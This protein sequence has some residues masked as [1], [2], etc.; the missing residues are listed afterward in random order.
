MSC[1]SCDLV[2]CLDSRNLRYC[3]T[4]VNHVVLLSYTCVWNLVF[5]CCLVVLLM[6]GGKLI[7]LVWNLVICFP[8]VIATK[9]ITCLKI[10]GF[11]SPAG[12]IAGLAASQQP[13]LFVFYLLESTMLRL[14]SLFVFWI[15]KTCLR[16]WSWTWNIDLFE[17]SWLCL[18]LN[19]ESWSLIYMKFR[20]LHFLGK[21]AR[22]S[23]SPA[24]TRKSPKLSG[25]VMKKPG[26]A[27]TRNFGLW[28]GFE[29]KSARPDPSPNRQ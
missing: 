24:R 23:P 26:P 19:F 28:A 17:L 22:K 25:F 10:S 1:E 2:Y 29:Q 5:D 4:K 20:L 8:I 14:L 7:C 16:I 3:K 9:V 15:I 12:K 27:R 13:S 6:S 18:C 11:T 21:K